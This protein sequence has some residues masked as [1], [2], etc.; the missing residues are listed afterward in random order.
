MHG[1]YRAHGGP[2]RTGHD[3]R[4]H[5]VMR[6]DLIRVGRGVERELLFLI[7]P[8][9]PSL[10]QAAAVA[11]LP[12]PA[13]PPAKG[14]DS[15]SLDAMDDPGTVLLLLLFVLVLQTLGR[16]AWCGSM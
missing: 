1:V 15:S 13:I 3:P 11:I 14:A 2:V 9:C 7:H 8:P 4:A 16:S 10:L 12:P 6:L 5:G